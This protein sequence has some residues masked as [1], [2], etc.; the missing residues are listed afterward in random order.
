MQNADNITKFQA[1]VD[2][3]VSL[4]NE[5]RPIVKSFE[6][7]PLREVV[8]DR[9]EGSRRSI[10]G[11]LEANI[12]SSLVIAIQNYYSIH[13]GYGIFKKVAIADGQIKVGMHTIDV[14]AGFSPKSGNEIVRLLMPVKTRETEG[15][16]HS[17]LF[18]RDIFAAI[19]DIKAEIPN[20]R[21]AVVIVAEN[22][23]ASEINKI[24]H[25]IDTVFHFNISPNMFH[26]FD[27]ESQIK[28]NQYI[29]RIFNGE[30]K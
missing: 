10:S 20:H 9:L 11:H 26:G 28:L 24:D 2:S 21:I 13:N 18:T 23:S 17:H 6:W 3:L 4:I 14:S 5:Y 8:I 25:S 1:E 19:S 12:R 16:G 22:W 7:Q 29:E 27:D 15:G 30:Y